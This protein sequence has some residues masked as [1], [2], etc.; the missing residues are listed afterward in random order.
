MAGKYFLLPS[1]HEAQDLPSH[2]RGCI[3]LRRTPAFT[4][5]YLPVG[6]RLR[7]HGHPH[8]VQLGRSVLRRV[9]DGDVVPVG[10]EVDAGKDLFH[11]TG[12][13]PRIRTGVGAL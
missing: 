1:S 11:G 10:G 4:A 2:H 3:W 6:S 12:H 5:H 7:K 9:P 13:S 8:V